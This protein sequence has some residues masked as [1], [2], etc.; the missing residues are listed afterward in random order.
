MYH[1]WWALIVLPMLLGTTIGILIYRNQDSPSVR[2][3]QL[4]S[5]TLPWL[6]LWELEKLGIVNDK[7]PYI[8]WA[9][10]PMAVYMLSLVLAGVV[11]YY[12]TT[13]ITRRQTAARLG[14]KI[15]DLELKIAE[16]QGEESRTMPEMV[17]L[18][19]YA[20]KLNHQAI[21]SLDRLI[22]SG[23]QGAYLIL[24]ELMSELLEKG[25]PNEIETFDVMTCLT[26]K[27][28]GVAILSYLLE[29][30]KRN[31]SPD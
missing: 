20:R 18:I 3:L 30:S 21:E 17:S 22:Q 27:I 23:N 19:E 4:L 8:Y 1:Y 10:M 13:I 25:K 2:I 16:R 6:M 31:N 29:F 15:N 28:N 9:C 24:K 26:D 12:S 7:M 14:E 11:L 5:V